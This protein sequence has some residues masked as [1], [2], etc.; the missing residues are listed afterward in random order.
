MEEFVSS[1]FLGTITGCSAIITL[2]V[3]VLKK[4]LPDNVDP[5]WLALVFSITVGALRMIYVGEFDFD[6]IVAG[7][8]NI[9][10]LL[11]GSIGIYELGLKNL[12]KG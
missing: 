5:K 7:I 12:Q 9:F 1:E 10:V 3:Q 8:I 11:S 2:C 4:F 6:G